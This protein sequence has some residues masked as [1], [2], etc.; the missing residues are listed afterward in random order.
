MTASSKHLL[1][2]I[3]SL[4]CISAWAADTAPVPL[5]VA[6]PIP[7][8]TPIPTAHTE[9][10]IEGWT[11]RVDDRLLTGDGAAL[12]ERAL[13]LLNARLVAITMV[14]PD[15]ALAGLRAV[16]IE[17]DLDYAGL[18]PMQYHPGADW[19]KL[20]GYSE[21]L[22]KCVHIPEAADF[23]SPFE[24]HRMPWV[25]LHELSHAYHDQVLGFDEPRIIAAWKKFRDCGKYTSVMTST[26]IMREH[27]GLTN[28]KEFFAEMTETYF[29]SNDFYPFVAGELMQAEP[30]I[31]A[32]MAAIWGPLPDRA[33]EK[34]KRK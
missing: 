15:K 17:L 31:F 12:G 21:S 10:N 3:I 23:L 28:A 25:I 27:Y 13:K 18:N 26:G 19:L 32:L 14:V 8:R 7:N 9:R 4:L 5:P 30:E 1:A 16:H 34:S 20:K 11:V 6:L 2:V 29:G 24:N 22:A 33:K